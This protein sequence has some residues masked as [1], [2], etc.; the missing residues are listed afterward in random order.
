MITTDRFKDRFNGFTLIELLVVI[1]LI[2]LISLISLPTISSYFKI[3]L[4]TV[5]RELASAVRETYTSTAL[6]GK[7]HRLVYDL[8]EHTY[9]AEIGPNIVLL[10]TQET[11]EKLDRKKRFSSTSE[12]KEAPSLFSLDKSITRKKRS[13]PTGVFF[14]D[15]LTEQSKESIKEGLVYTHFF[16]HGIT[17]QTILHIKDSANHK[18]SLVL[19][20][21]IGR[22]EMYEKFVTREEANGQL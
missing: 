5:A 6:T 15:I 16:P 2:A 21:I 17:E 13:L 7:V 11:K 8:N 19:K 22:T 3:S 4:T 18:I 9:W 10:D 1:F 14:E 20:P 12:T